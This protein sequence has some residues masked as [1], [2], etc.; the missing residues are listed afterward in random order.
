M[1]KKQNL[2]YMCH[3]NK[4]IIARYDDWSYELKLPP[5][6]DQESDSADNPPHG[7]YDGD[8]QGCGFFFILVIVILVVYYLMT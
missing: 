1:K 3:V 4:L 7:N 6:F 8:G 5:Y 2:A